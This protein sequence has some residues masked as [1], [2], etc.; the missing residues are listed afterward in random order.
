MSTSTELGVLPARLPARF[1]FI[2][3]RDFPLIPLLILGIIAFVA[4][5][6]DV[7]APYDPEIGSLSATTWAVMCCRD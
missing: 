7:L 5:F 3:A 4:V 2:R 6:A 1:S